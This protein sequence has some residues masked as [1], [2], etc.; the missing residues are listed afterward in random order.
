MLPNVRLNEVERTLMVSPN[1]SSTTASTVANRRMP[2]VQWARCRASAARQIL[3]EVPTVE[4]KPKPRM[5]EELLADWRAAERESEGARTAEGVAGLAVE[6]ADAA[7]AAAAESE[8]AVTSAAAA[9]EHAKVASDLART[10]AAQASKAAQMIHAEAT[11]AEERAAET[12]E[13][14]EADRSRAAQ[15]FR[16]AQARGFRPKQD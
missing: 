4:G 2:L 7:K 1:H 14:A 8:A 3:G 13:E 16:E 11:D 10:A 15:A 6:T 5:A 9:V 12:V